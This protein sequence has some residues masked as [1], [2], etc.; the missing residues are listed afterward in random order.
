[1]ELVS[2]RVLCVEENRCSLERRGGRAPGGNLHFGSLCLQQV[3][4]PGG[5]E[6]ENNLSLHTHAC[7][8]THKHTHT[9][10]HTHMHTHTQSYSSTLIFSYTHLCT[11]TTTSSHL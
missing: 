4:L 1:M 11:H 5:R 10:T 3:G 7:T 8:H 6:P 2:P 9:H